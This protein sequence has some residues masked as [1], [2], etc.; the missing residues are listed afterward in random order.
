MMKIINFKILKS[1]RQKIKVRHLQKYRSQLS[2]QP[3][4]AEIHYNFANS[5]NKLGL[6]NLSNAELRSAEYLGLDSKKVKTLNNKNRELLRELTDLD[7]NQYQRF[8]I[9][10][11]HLSELLEN[12]DSILDVGGGHGILSQF[13]PD[14]RYFL[15]EPSVNG[16]SGLKLPFTDNSFDAVVTCHVL[17]HIAADNRPMFINEL[18]RVSRKNV[19]IFNPF[20][21]EHLDELERL[22]LILDV[23]K[24]AWAKEHIECGLPGIEEITDYLSS[25]HLSFIIKEYGDIYSA[26][27]TIFMSY[28][29]EKLYADDLVKINRHLNQKYDQLGSSKYPVNIMI[30]IKKCSDD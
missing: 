23:T 13:M 27:A 6:Y 29:S 10:Q 8:V 1:L 2:L 30:V 19:L 22:K 25:Q 28:F 20:K 3:L 11:T 12:G 24:A 5:A 9:L 17:E 14:N 7:V 26:V 4:N 15:V 16:V 18:V 21:N